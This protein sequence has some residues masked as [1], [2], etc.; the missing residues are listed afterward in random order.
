M[1]HDPGTIYKIHGSGVLS[2]VW[3]KTKQNKI[4]HVLIS[5]MGWFSGNLVL[6]V[7]VFREIKW[8]I[9]KMFVVI[10]FALML[11]SYMYQ[12]LTFFKGNVFH[13]HY[14]HIVNGKHRVKIF[15]LIQ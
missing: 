3:E 12:Q 7:L 13:R 10:Y 8:A 15:N 4:K 1:W 5:G 2:S 9:K 6:N 11:L 14:H